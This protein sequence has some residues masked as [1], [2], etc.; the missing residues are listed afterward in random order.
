MTTNK[1][2]IVMTVY[3]V[4]LLLAIVA[5]MVGYHYS[6]QLGVYIPQDDPLNRGLYTFMILYTIVTLPIALKLYSV[7]E[8]KARKLADRAERERRIMWY[9]VAKVSVIGLGFVANILL[10]YMLRE[11]SMLY[12]AGISAIGMLFAKPKRKDMFR[13][14]EEDEAPAEGGEE[15]K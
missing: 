9:G 2:Y 13:Q 14:E 8:R 10:F 11:T 12:M 1:T 7:G 3:Y 15:K 6:G 4:M 5:A